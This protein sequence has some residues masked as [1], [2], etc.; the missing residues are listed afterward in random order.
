MTNYQPNLDHT[1]HALADATRRRVL[2]RLMLGPASVKDLAAPFQMALPSFLQH[3]KVLER[4]ALVRSVKNGRVRTFQIEPQQMQNA[5][6]WLHAQL[7]MWE[8][9]LDQLDAYLKELATA[10]GENE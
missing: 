4:S 7:E 3:M 8:R 10:E 2:E 6:H 9:R 1:F 5:T